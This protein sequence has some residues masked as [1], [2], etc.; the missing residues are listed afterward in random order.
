MDQCQA[1][2]VGISVNGKAKALLPTGCQD[3]AQPK[4]FKLLNADV[5]VSDNGG[6]QEIRL[7]AHHEG[8]YQAS[9]EGRKCSVTTCFEEVKGARMGVPY[10]RKHLDRA[11]GSREPSTDPPK[12]RPGKTS[13]A[14]VTSTAPHVA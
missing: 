9:W 3:K 14:D 8:L 2:R 6:G 13:E 7:C 1:I 10:C 5:E 4:A 11:Q 12:R